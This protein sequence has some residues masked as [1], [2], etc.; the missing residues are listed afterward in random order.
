MFLILNIYIFTV[1]EGY[2]KTNF[3]SVHNNKL[4][5][6]IGCGSIT[7]GTFKLEIHI[8]NFI[9]D[10]YYELDIRKGDKIEVIGIMSNTG[11]YRYLIY[12]DI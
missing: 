8:V 3:S 9:D 11:T 5:K 4:N 2:V 12:L 7:D 1:L 10:D 6:M